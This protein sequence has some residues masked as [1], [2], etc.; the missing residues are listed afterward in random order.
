MRFNVILLVVFICTPTIESSC[1][2]TTQYYVECSQTRTLSQSIALCQRYGMWLLNL[3]NSSQLTN[4]I[5]LIN[6]TL[7]QCQCQSPFWFSSGN[8]TGFVGSTET[9][10]NVFTAIFAGSLNVVGALL[11]GLFGGVGCLLGVLCPPT[12]TTTTTTSMPITQ[13]ITICSREAQQLVIQKCSTVAG[14]TDLRS[15]HFI[16]RTMFVGLLDTFDTRTISLCSGL[17]SSNVDCI[18]I[19]YTNGTCTLYL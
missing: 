2:A 3:T 19:S 16:K 1:P 13:A 15:Y 4:Q 6:D 9:L 12:T 5:M 18:G 17:C 11:G 14:R 8:K 7:E 10:G